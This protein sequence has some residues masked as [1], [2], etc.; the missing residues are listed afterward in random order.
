MD[1]AVRRAASVLLLRPQ[2]GGFQVYLQH[3]AASM[4]FAG[5]MIAFPGGGVDPADGTIRLDGVDLDELA[6]AFGC[7]RP[8]AGSVLAAA[9]REV[10]EET[11]VLLTPGA[12]R[13]WARW[14]TPPGQSRR[15]DTF[16]LAAELPE[17][18]RARV[19]TAESSADH[20]LTPRAALQRAQAGEWAMLPPTVAMLESLA[21]HENVVG[22]LSHRPTIALVE[23]EVV[24]AP[25][26]PIVV[27]VGE[28]EY[29]ALGGPASHR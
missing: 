29:R 12:L 17:G 4:R 11:G 3:R 2:P 10:A 28:R 20:W 25:G 14:L 1:Q 16:F 8:V 24:S 5:G 27:R 15:Y 21:A 9:V 22:V 23:P 7:P 18:Q 26:E 19:A 13:P 6:A